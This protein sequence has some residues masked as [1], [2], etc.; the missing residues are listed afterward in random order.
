M[1]TTRRLMRLAVLI[2]AAATIMAACGSD[3]ATSDSSSTSG[4]D[5]P[6]E[7]SAPSEEE[8]GPLT[9]AYQADISSFD[10]DNNFEVAGLGAINAVYEGLVEYGPDSTDVVGLLASDWE[11]SPDGLTYT[12]TIREGVEFHD[13][14]PMD[15]NSV[16]TSLERRWTNEELAL[17]Y[18][19][20]NV[21]TLDAPDAT[22]LVMTLNDPQPS[23]LDNLASPWG[24]KVVS[25]TALEE[26]AG[27]DNAATWLNENAVGTGPFQLTEFSRGDRYVLDRFDSYWGSVANTERIVVRIVPE[28]SQQVLQLADGSLDAVLHGYP[29][30]QL[31]GLPDGVEATAYDDLG[32]ELAFINPNKTLTTVELRN[33]VISAV[34]PAAWLDGA[35]GEYASLPTSLFPV[36]MIPDAPDLAW[37]TAADGVEVPSIEIWFSAE[38]ASTQK[39][40]ADLLVAQLA[41]SG[42]DSTSRGVP[43]TQIQSIPNNPD[44]APDVVI[45]QNYPDSAHPDSQ[46][47]L[48]Y[49]SEGPLN[50]FGANA[51]VDDMIFTAGAIEDPAESIASYLDISEQLLSEGVFAPLGNIQ[52]VIVHRGLTDL[53]T[54]PAIPWTVDFGTV[55]R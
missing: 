44:T 13:G 9:F 26:N 18:F 14:T 30:E 52:N 2:I 45:A 32:L 39:R 24:P 43:S 35:F 40:V 41:A 20:F 46:A 42:I 7:T 36:A 55:G 53:N 47:F 17:N 23:L 54:R 28:I 50:L 48:F 51:E 34:D 25:P 5:S 19:L 22:T 38:E 12:F 37:P 10:P 6:D 8:G 49:F 27:E 1:T 11:V 33:A 15:A 4:A 29:F 16:K 31:A 3:E 21:A